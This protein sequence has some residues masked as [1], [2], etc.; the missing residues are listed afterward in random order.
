M[1]TVTLHRLYHVN[2]GFG[3]HLLLYQIGDAA[4]QAGVSL[5]TVRF[6]QQKGLIT[7][8]ARTSSGMSLYSPGE[9]NRIRFIRR[10]KNAGISL[11]EIRTLLNPG[12]KSDIKDRALQTLEVLKRE[13]TSTRLRIAELERQNRECHKIMSL[14]ETCLKCGGGSCPDDCKP[15]QYLI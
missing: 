15:K 6:Y 3:N 2:G 5:R 9:V 13:A 14:V 8:Y 12:A 1:L 10:L 7:H 4:R 11:D